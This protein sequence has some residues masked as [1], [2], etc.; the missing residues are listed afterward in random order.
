VSRT[1]L[2]GVSPRG[3]IPSAYIR[4]SRRGLSPSA[5]TARGLS[6]S[7]YTARG[8]SPSAHTRNPK[9]S[10]TE[11]HVIVCCSVQLSLA[12]THTLSLS[13]THTHTLCLAHTHAH[14]LSHTHT[15]SLTRALSPSFLLTLCL[16]LSLSEDDILQCGL[17]ARQILDRC[18]PSEGGP[19]P[20]VRRH[21][22]GHTLVR[23]V[24]PAITQPSL[25]LARA[26]SRALSL[27]PSL[28]LSLSLSPAIGGV[29]VAVGGAT[30]S[31][32]L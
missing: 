32:R 10:I 20:R 15:L 9:A 26:L 13:H 16:L 30:R 18:V 27:P 11:K 17:G 24:S 28:S 2:H 19:G 29:F 6:P 7:A 14:F 4:L 21:R 1:T 25:S 3:L 8:L 31:C 5:C 12:H 23:V 22:R